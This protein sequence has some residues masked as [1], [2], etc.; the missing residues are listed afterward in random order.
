MFHEHS[1]IWKG[2]EEEDEERKREDME[3]TGR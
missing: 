2:K 3:L 1:S